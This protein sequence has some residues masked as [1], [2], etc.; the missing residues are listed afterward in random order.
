MEP[1]GRGLLPHLS[2]SSSAHSEVVGYGSFIMKLQDR[3]RF[4][5]Y[6][7]VDQT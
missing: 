5:S 3:V 6:V 1:G 4:N 7:S 2:S